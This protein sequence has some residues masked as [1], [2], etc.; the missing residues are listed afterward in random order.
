MFGPGSGG[1][2]TCTWS[3]AERLLAA[4]VPPKSFDDLPPNALDLL[5]GHHWPGNVREL[6]N[7][8]ARLLL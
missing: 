7:I 1:P 3:G 6:R 5:L 4:Q 2:S 8:V